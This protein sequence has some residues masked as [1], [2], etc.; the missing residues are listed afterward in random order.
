MRAC[1]RKLD[2]R[3]VHAPSR[4]TRLTDKQRDWE[5]KE[6]EQNS[7]SSGKDREQQQRR[8]KGSLTNPS[9]V[10]HITCYSRCC[11][12]DTGIVRLFLVHEDERLATRIRVPFREQR[13]LT[14]TQS[15]TELQ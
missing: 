10:R 13:L 5:R 7:R 9:L 11:S 2:A 15:S 14:Q 4:D 1:H 8:Q 3:E 6:R 12:T